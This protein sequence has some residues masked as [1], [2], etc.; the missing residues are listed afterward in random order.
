MNT[1][2]QDSKPGA[3]A[4]RIVSVNDYGPSRRSWL[5]RLAIAG[6]V[7][8]IVVVGIVRTAVHF[9][10]QRRAE[11]NTSAE[12]AKQARQP[13]TPAKRRIFPERAAS[14][15]TAPEVEVGARCSDASEATPL[16]A[17]DG[18][19]ILT[20]G[21]LPVRQCRNGQILMPPLPVPEAAP[22]QLAAK[23]AA[24]ASPGS[25]AQHSDARY[26][27]DLVLATVNAP[28]DSH[29]DRV[30][31][32]SEPGTAITPSAPDAPAD[33]HGPL[34]A[35]LRTAQAGVA[36]ARLLGNRDLVL[37]ESRSI[38]CNLSLRIVTEVSG[39]AVCIV[40]SY[41]YG[42]TGMVALIEPGSVASGSYVALSAP[43][44]RRVFIVWNRLQTTKGVVIDLDSPASDALGTSG[45]DGYLDNRWA[46]RI[47]AAVLLSTVQDV[48]GYETARA[49]S[50]N[51]GGANG[52]AIFPQ[53]TRTGQQLAEKILDSTI[54][55][56]PTLYK[57]QG[58]RA[59]ITVA[60]DLDFGSVYELRPR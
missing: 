38:D 51:G 17:R 5:P 16:L 50:S 55:I 15:P 6:A 37:P 56:K 20:P 3:A 44:Q 42:A 26:D 46:D 4:E 53:T 30:A 19:V 32:V 43:G 11:Q 35:L 41:V 18:T 49:G 54:N 29:A 39:K 22:A 23:P 31:I 60:R 28:T 33:P 48:I 25:G 57:H 27:G 10:G 8:L 36:Q 12:Q 52:I 47:G 14:Q 34:P 9:I 13:Q 24:P 58:D 21:G 1:V 45:L 2:D 40:S 59:T 7:M